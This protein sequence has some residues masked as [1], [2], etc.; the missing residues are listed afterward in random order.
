MPTPPALY[1]LITN[2]GLRRV[3]GQ[4]DPVRDVR[5]IRPDARRVVEVGAGGGYYT[6]DLAAHLGPAAELTAVDPDPDAVRALAAAGS[7]LFDARCADGADLPFPDASMDAA[8]YSYS[9]EEFA[10][11][12]AGLAEAARVLRPGG[13]L[14]LFLW[15][16][17]ALGTRRVRREL[18]ATDRF[19]PE[20]THLTPQNLRIRLRRAPALTLAG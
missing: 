6:R 19:T 9:L 20:R 8:L 4:D 18:G 7:G 3:L 15:R 10:D 16:F 11:P 12:G 17:N 2:H 13:Q 5:W 1:S 14:V